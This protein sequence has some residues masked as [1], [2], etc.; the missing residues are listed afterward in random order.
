MQHQHSKDK[1]LDL[2]ERG[3]K[4]ELGSYL[5]LESFTNHSLGSDLNIHLLS[6]REIGRRE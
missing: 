2:K 1:E 6:I 5:M 4:L 3:T